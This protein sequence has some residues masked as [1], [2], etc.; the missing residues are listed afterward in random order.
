VIPALPEDTGRLSV[1][2]SVRRILENREGPLKPWDIETLTRVLRERAEDLLG[3]L[4]A[5]RNAADTMAL[6]LEVRDAYG[7]LS[8]GDERDE[9]D[10]EVS[11]V[12]EHMR[13][14]L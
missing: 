4:H 3:L 6:A 7:R 8:P 14:A 12:M 5:S 10:A 13:G 2:E 1:R 11:Y 9:R